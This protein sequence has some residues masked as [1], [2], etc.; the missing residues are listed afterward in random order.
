MP[1]FAYGKSA[2]NAREDTVYGDNGTESGFL[3]EYHFD[4]RNGP[5]YWSGDHIGHEAQEEWTLDSNSAV[6]F[7]RKADAEMVMV[8][9]LGLKLPALNVRAELHEWG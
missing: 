5:H 7:S 2:D 3:I 8:G 6:R 9:V 1:R 4:D